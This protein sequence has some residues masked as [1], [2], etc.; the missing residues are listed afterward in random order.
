M[1]VISGE[2]VAICL[3]DT[4]M[5]LLKL[6][7]PIYVALDNSMLSHVRYRFSPKLLQ[8]ATNKLHRLFVIIIIT[9]VVCTLEFIV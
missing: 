2:N 6:S 3:V 5:P 4:V 1:L 7:L 8:L 9:P